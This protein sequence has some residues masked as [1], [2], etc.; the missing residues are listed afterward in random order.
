MTTTLLVSCTGKNNSNHSKNIKTMNQSDLKN[1]KTKN[2]EFLKDMYQDDYFPEH[3]VDKGK[4][5]LI[6]LCR[7][8]EIQEPSSLEELYT[9]THAA[10]ERFNDLED[11]FAENES[12]METAAAEAIAMDFAFIAVSYGYDADVEELIGPRTW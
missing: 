6:D 4:A 12:E 10:T 8:I 11:E 3:L 1:E 2:Y 7:Q 5:I 9:L